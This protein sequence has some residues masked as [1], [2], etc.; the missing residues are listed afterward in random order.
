[1]THE[2]PTTED[3]PWADGFYGRCGMEFEQ[4][5][6]DHLKRELPDLGWNCAILEDRQVIPRHI[7]ECL[8]WMCF[9]HDDCSIAKTQVGD[10]EVSTAFLITSVG[11][12]EDTPLHFE[13]MIFGP[14]RSDT[15]GRYATQDEAEQAH[16]RAVQQAKNLDWNRRHGR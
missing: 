10:Y 9:H 7:S 1:M 3:G 2:G 12:D 6:I 4:Q 11:K 14:D 13:I 15:Y 8:V 5:F 16:E